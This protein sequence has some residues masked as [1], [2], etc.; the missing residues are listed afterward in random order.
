MAITDLELA[1]SVSIFV[2]FFAILNVWLRNKSHKKLQKSEEKCKLLVTELSE[3]LRIE[4]QVF[5]E[6]ERFKTTLVSAGD[7]II[8]TDQ[9]GNI[10]F[11]NKVAE[12]LTGWT[13]E[14]ASGK[15]FDEIFNTINEFAREKGENLAKT[16]L[17]SGQP[18]VDANHRILISKDGSERPIEENAAPIKDKEGTINGVVIVFSDYTEAKERQNS[19]EYL[20][21]RDQL[22]GLYNRRFYEEELKR[23]NTE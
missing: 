5:D 7:G 18:F 11:M 17:D 2:I 13:Q 20:S 8:S 19:I 4:K 6:K 21:Y 15:T 23:L 12:Q 1:I 3:R 16:I 9:Q 10:E 14:E 22:T